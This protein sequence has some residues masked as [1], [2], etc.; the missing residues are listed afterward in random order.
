MS[1]V[2]MPYLTYGLGYEE[3]ERVIGQ[4]SYSKDVLD[5][6]EHLIKKYPAEHYSITHHMFSIGFHCGQ[7]SKNSEGTA[8]GK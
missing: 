7:R 6:A 8:D 4:E 3:D 2:T 1:K 5:L